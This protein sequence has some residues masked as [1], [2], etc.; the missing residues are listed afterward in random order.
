MD[1]DLGSGL[2]LLY[3]LLGQ[4]LRWALGY[5]IFGFRMFCIA[6]GI[7]S[8]TRSDV[9]KSVALSCCLRIETSGLRSRSGVCTGVMKEDFL[10]NLMDIAFF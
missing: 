3:F 7:G 10:R 5:L 8:C 6:L 9:G 4:N 1:L 2:D